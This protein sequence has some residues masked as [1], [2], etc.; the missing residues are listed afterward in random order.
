[1]HALN[2]VCELR[3]QGALV[4]LSA[5]QDPCIE[6][7]CLASGVTFVNKDLP[8]V[9]FCRHCSVPCIRT[10]RFRYRSICRRVD[11]CTIPFK[12]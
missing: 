8:L 9:H 12:V 4:V 10:F 6:A 3:P 1:L 11:L 7:A 2:T 5:L